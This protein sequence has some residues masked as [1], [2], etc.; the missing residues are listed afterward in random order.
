MQDANSRGGMI[1][2]IDMNDAARTSGTGDAA[3]TAT[4]AGG[5]VPP[6]PQSSAQTTAHGHYFRACP[7][8]AIDVYRVLELFAVTDPVLQHIVKKALC[9]GQRGAKDRERDICDIR[10]SAARRLAML[11]EDKALKAPQ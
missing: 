6:P 2:A 11:D 10:D 3:T 4:T 8:P 5:H 9:A 1:A 7:Y